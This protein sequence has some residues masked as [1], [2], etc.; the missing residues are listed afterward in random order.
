MDEVT[1]Q[2]IL[3]RHAEFGYHCQ[4]QGCDKPS[5]EIAHRLSNGKH[6][7]ARVISYCESLNIFL[8]ASQVESII[9]HDLNTIPTCREHNVYMALH[10]SQTVAVMKLIDAILKDLDIGVVKWCVT[11]TVHTVDIIKHVLTETSAI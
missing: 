1:R 2:K 10:V 11:M 4:Y 3:D 8:T 5:T 9:H 6:G 7:R